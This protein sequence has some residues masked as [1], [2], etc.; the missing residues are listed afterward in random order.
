MPSQDWNFHVE[1]QLGLGTGTSV[2]QYILSLEP[3][4]PAVMQRYIACYPGGIDAT[5]TSWLSSVSLSPQSGATHFERG[6]GYG[7]TVTFG[8][9]LVG[10][11]PFVRRHRQHVAR[12][13]IR[14]PGVTVTH[15]NF[16]AKTPGNPTE[17][18]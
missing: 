8:L 2:V 16:R 1:V 15:R 7:D 18:L 17:R 6:T 4:G 3:V 9:L 5:V 12:R 10:N 13:P 11:V 14:R